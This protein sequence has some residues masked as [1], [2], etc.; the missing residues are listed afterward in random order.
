MKLLA[1]LYIIVAFR[2][3]TF[4]DG[5]GRLKKGGSTHSSLST[6]KLP[7]ER[8]ESKDPPK[9]F[10]IDIDGTLLAKNKEGW[11]RNIE[12]FAK[13]REMGY[14][15]FLCTGNSFGRSMSKLGQEFI[16]RTGYKGYPGVYLHGIQIYDSDGNRLKPKYNVPTFLLWIKSAILVDIIGR[17]ICSTFMGKWLSNSVCSINK[18][19]GIKDLM[20]P[21]GVPPEQCGFIGNDWNDIQAMDFCDISFAVGNAPDYVKKH[22][23]VVLDKTCDEGAVAEALK[24]VYGLQIP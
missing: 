9:Y 1:V 2:P 8:P 10:A 4:G 23:K 24:I 16:E 20:K 22:A 3:A 11:E 19:T 13:A 18:A 17:F 21:L 15:P 5:K 12:A 14:T 7:E 6:F